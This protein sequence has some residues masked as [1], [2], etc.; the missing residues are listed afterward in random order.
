M[1]VSDDGTTFDFNP[2]TIAH[3]NQQ[4]SD[5][6]YSIQITKT[7]VLYAAAEDGIARSTPVIFTFQIQ[8]TVDCSTYV[9]RTI[10]PLLIPSVF[11]KDPYVVYVPIDL[12]HDSDGVSYSSLT[13]CSHETPTVTS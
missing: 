4:E 8:V 7:S 10:D 2:T 1:T 3:F 6:F 13:E 11:Y 9:F 5:V 12:E